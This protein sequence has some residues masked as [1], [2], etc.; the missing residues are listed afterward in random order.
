[1]STPYNDSMKEQILSV[2]C[3]LWENNPASVTVRGIAR[4]IGCVHGTVLWHFGSLDELKSAIAEYAVK[5][6][7]DKVIAHLI[8]SGHDAV[9]SLP[10][11]ARER[12]MRT[13]ARA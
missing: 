8:V 13:A 7:N 9:K 12:H 4:V 6:G 11:A 10:L 2:G 5:A 3:E 1:M